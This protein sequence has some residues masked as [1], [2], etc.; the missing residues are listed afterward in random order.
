M[1]VPRKGPPNHLVEDE[2]F[3]FLSQREQKEKEGEKKQIQGDSSRTEDA[4]VFIYGA[5]PT[6]C[7]GVSGFFFP[8]RI[9]ERGWTLCLQSYGMK[10]ER[11]LND[12]T[13]LTSRA[14][15]QGGLS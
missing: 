11:H 4:P 8:L 1:R 2:E 15:R 10:Q 6:Q 3:V 14:E 7:C 13:A 9:I 5:K 12:Q